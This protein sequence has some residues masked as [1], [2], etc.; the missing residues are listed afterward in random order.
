MT[1]NGVKNTGIRENNIESILHLLYTKNLSATHIAKAL[2]LSKTAVFKILLE[3]EHMNLVENLAINGDDNEKYKRTLYTIKQEAGILGVLEFGSTYIKIVFSYLNGQIFDETIIEDREFLTLDD[4]NEISTIIL[5]KKAQFETDVCKMISVIVSTPGQ[6]NKFKDEIENSVKFKRIK[7]IPIRAF[8][9]ERLNLTVMLKNDINLAII[10]EKHFGKMERIADNGIL[11]YIDSGMG[12]AILNENNIIEG[13]FGYA[14]EF[15]LISTYD[16]FGNNIVYDLICSI[17]S[18]KKQIAYQHFM[19]KQTQL[20]PTFRYRHVVKAFYDKDPVILEVVKYTAH[21]I[22]E[23][24]SN[25]SYIF[26]YQQF[27]IGGRIKALGDQYLEWVNEAI[28]K[29]IKQISIKY[30]T[31][32]DENIIYGAIHIGVTN[33][34]SVVAKK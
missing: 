24:I 11:I 26:N 12:G 8:F 2:K 17:N 34:F 7:E 10:G 27:F 20:P 30:T 22:G 23:L 9:E 15:G 33:A 1:A 21:K 31:L 32:G 19:G 28:D 13:D 25:L 14:A 16:Q 18:I 6:I 29:N 4:L 3:M 5:N